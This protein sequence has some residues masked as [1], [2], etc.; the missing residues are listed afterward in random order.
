MHTLRRAV[1][2]QSV[3]RG[4]NKCLP[5]PVYTSRIQH[6]IYTTRLYNTPIQHSN[7]KI[8]RES[9]TSFYCSDKWRHIYMDR[10]GNQFILTHKMNKSKG[11]E[12]RK[13]ISYKQ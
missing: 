1:V 8:K 6:E 13:K 4:A 2:L 3:Y 9:K 10:V 7:W 12:N 5:E 11:I